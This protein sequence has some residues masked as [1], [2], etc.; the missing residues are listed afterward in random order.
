MNRNVLLSQMKERVEA[1]FAAQDLNLDQAKPNNSDSIIKSH[2]PLEHEKNESG[3]PKTIDLEIKELPIDDC[4]ETEIIQ[5][6]TDKDRTEVNEAIPEVHEDKLEAKET[7][8]KSPSTSL[9][10]LAVSYSEEQDVSIP[11]DDSFAK[12]T[13]SIL[14]AAASAFEAYEYMLLWYPLSALIPAPTSPRPFCITA[15]CASTLATPE[16]ST[17]LLVTPT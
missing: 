1:A 12:S 3:E 6:E 13:S 9:S 11:E 8:S 7:N 5:S 4:E 17:G 14:D 16:V 2:L 15:I 10:L